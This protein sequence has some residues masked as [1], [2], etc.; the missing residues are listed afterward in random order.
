MP[1]QTSP[2]T[3]ATTAELLARYKKLTQ[4]SAFIKEHDSAAQDA[5][6]KELAPRILAGDLSGK[7]PLK[8]DR[9]DGDDVTGLLVIQPIKAPKVK[10][11]SPVEVAKQ[12]AST[13]KLRAAMMCVY[14]Q[15]RTKS[16]VATNGHS[17]AVLPSDQVGEADL[18]LNPKTGAALAVGDV[19][20]KGFA[21]IEKSDLRYPDYENAIPLAGRTNPAVTLNV[22]Q[23]EVLRNRLAGICKAERFVNIYRGI[24]AFIDF[25]EVCEDWFAFF[26]ASHLLL[27]IT[28][29]LATGS[30]RVQLELSTPNRA[31]VLRDSDNHAK[32]V[33]VMPIMQGGFGYDANP[34]HALLLSP[35]TMPT[36]QLAPAPRKPRAQKPAARVTMAD[37]TPPSPELAAALTE[38]VECATA[39][40]EAERQ[41][42]ELRARISHHLRHES[43]HWNESLVWCEAADLALADVS[44]N[45]PAAST[46]PAVPV[47][48]FPFTQYRLEGCRVVLLHQIGKAAVAWIYPPDKEPYLAVRYRQHYAHV[49]TLPDLPIVFDELRQ[50]VWGYRARDAD[51]L[52]FSGAMEQLGA[53]F[54][55]LAAFCAH[56][57]LLRSQPWPRY[58]IRRAII[59]RKEPKWQHYL[60]CLNRLK[61]TN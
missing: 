23:L 35:A 39:L 55:C 21:P 14:H 16:V 20:G 11:T 41:P 26:N 32:L 57:D 47:K 49:D 46:S 33:L 44:P 4:R 22:A 31:L 25:R 3:V 54:S 29:L 61:P 42:E 19:M 59:N 6:M 18:L 30:K 53:D 27:A 56:H 43:F 36:E 45:L 40:V 34:A 7:A 58:L 13:N 37:N 10:Q 2:A 8:K 28:G 15:A 9:I 51:M 1:T 17:L 60:N 24:H 52:S 48:K 38:L 5:E 50:K 12:F